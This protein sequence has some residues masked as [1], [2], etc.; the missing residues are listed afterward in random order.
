MSPLLVIFRLEVAFNTGA[1]RFLRTEPC[2]RRATWNIFFYFSLRHLAE[3]FKAP[4]HMVADG[5][6][7]NAED[8][9]EPAA[10]DSGLSPRPGAPGH[11]P[12]EGAGRSTFA[13]GPERIHVPRRCH[14]GCWGSNG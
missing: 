3:Y 7:L 10:S 4:T 12:G 14:C 6:C 2:Q 11:L 13:G 1:A 9:W 5:S 8:P